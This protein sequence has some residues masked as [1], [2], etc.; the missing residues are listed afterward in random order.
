LNYPG[1]VIPPQLY[2]TTMTETNDI[3]AA[4]AKQSSSSS[5][6]VRYWTQD[7]DSALKAAVEMM[8]QKNWKRIAKTA[9][10]NNSRSDIQCLHRWKK[11]LR[12]NLKKG[13]WTPIE[14]ELVFK[15]VIQVGTH[16]VKWSQVAN[17]LEGRLGKQV[18]ERWFNHLD[19]TLE[20][21][22]WK[23]AEDAALV[24]WQKEFGN[25]WVKIAEKMPGRSENAIKNR[26]NSAKRRRGGLDKRK[27]NSGKSKGSSSGGGGG[28]SNSGNK[29]LRTSSSSSSSSSD[30]V[31][32][33]KKLKK[34]KVDI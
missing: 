26:W 10:P 27:G 24:K 19:P 7:E 16:S 30:A 14:D 21:G 1:E 6:T 18:R 33:T 31:K 34:T 17:K 15:E 2:Q 25:K 32:S 20:K 11:V 9:F 22:P 29:R 3:V 8:N 23:P 5:T 28:T 12:P 4:A 13:P